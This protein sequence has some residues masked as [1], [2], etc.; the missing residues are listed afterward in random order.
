MTVL[1]T[2]RSDSAQLRSFDDDPVGAPP[3]GFTFAVAR[4]AAPAGWSVERQAGNGV[5]VHRRSGSGQGFALAVLDAPPL[6]SVEASVRMRLAGG[7]RAGGL[8]WRYQDEDNYFL[9]RLALGAR[10]LALYRVVRGN[11][12]RLEDEDDLELDPDAWHTLKIRHEG[13]RIR[14][15][16]GGIR[17]LE[18]YERS[19]PLEGRVGLWSADDSLGWFD[20]MRVSAGSN[21]REDPDR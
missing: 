10:D 8:V 21:R 20:D 4:G 13:E 7:A 3:P 16:L 18:D 5:L 1:L 15:Y 12:L 14:V 17:V 6:R 9:A 2:T 19:Q 11:R